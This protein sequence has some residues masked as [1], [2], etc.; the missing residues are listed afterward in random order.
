MQKLLAMLVLVPFAAVVVLS[1][2]DHPTAPEGAQAATTVQEASTPQAAKQPPTLPMAVRLSGVEFVQGT[3]N[4]Q[5]SIGYTAGSFAMCPSGK[6]PLSGGYWASPGD[7]N[8]RYI[9]NISQPYK[10]GS[11]IGWLASA[12]LTAGSGVS[13]TAYALCVDGDFGLE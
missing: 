5:V 1:C 2:D 13:V 6:V 11:E 7:P 10:S 9:V 3:T 4:S 12:M 8:S